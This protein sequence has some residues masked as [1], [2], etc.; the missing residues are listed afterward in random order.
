MNIFD[1]LTNFVA[2]LGVGSSKKG[3]DRFVHYERDFQQLEA[4]YRGDFL[5]RKVVDVPVRDVIRPWRS[6]QAKPEQITAIEDAEKQFEVKSELAKALAW[7]RLYG[8]SV[9]LIGAGDVDPGVPLVPA[10]VPK[11]GLRYL[12]SLPRKMVQV[13]EL[14]LDPAS[15]GFGSPKLYHIN[16]QKGGRI[17]IHPS[18]VLR[19]VGAPRPDLDLNAE[20]WGDS[21]LQVVYD[22]LHNAA[23]AMGGTSELV[24]EAKVDIVKIKNLAALLSTDS[25]TK[26][27]LDRFSNTAKLKSINNTF[28]LDAED[29]HNR[30]QT[31]F[32][33]LPDVIRVF[34][35]IVSAAADI[36]VTRLLGT[37]AKGLNATG[38]GDTRNYYDFL[39]GWRVENLAPALNTIDVLLWQH[40]LGAVPKDAYYQFN[41]LWQLSEKE[42]ADL[43]K[44][45]ADTAK[46]H[47]SLGLLPEEALAR[48]LAN[49]LIEDAVYPGFETEMA[50]LLASDEPIVPEDKPD[51]D[52]Q[53]G[54]NNPRA[55]R[56]SAQADHT[57]RGGAVDW[58]G[59]RSDP[60]AGLD[61]LLD[62]EVVPSQRH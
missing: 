32:T 16:T 13:S 18:R 26:V 49:Q 30:V 24:H 47:A 44:T 41:P 35:E 4:M 31:S 21:V 28:V 11:G 52:V 20:G 60:L 14:D 62:H 40:A 53:P 25:G 58:W 1:T 5:S 61:D 50:D 12:R 48:G 43:A 10:S 46:V 6:W 29:E 42:K 39:D 36:P 7:A 59:I 37:S 33:A 51:D 3:F 27:L 56:K 19:F 15:P 22:A 45:K 57:P 9:T 8:G 54:G 23:L 55:R 34:L 38:E 2:S 17:D